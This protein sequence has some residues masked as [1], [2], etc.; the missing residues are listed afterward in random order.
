MMVANTLS[1][2]N[3]FPMS[4]VAT[5]ITILTGAVSLIAVLWKVFQRFDQVIRQLQENTRLTG[6]NKM[7]VSSSSD[8]LKVEMEKQFMALQRFHQERYRELNKEIHTAKDEIIGLR[9]RITKLENDLRTH[10]SNSD[11]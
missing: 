8:S 2:I 6:E 7:I 3:Q 9:Q 4:D 5:A 10:L 1:L 11:N